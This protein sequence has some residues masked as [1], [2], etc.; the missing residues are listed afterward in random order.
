MHAVWDRERSGCLLFTSY[1]P[2]S[3]VPSAAKARREKSGD[4]QAFFE[5]TRAPALC[6][7]YTNV[8]L[9]MERPQRC[10]IHPV[11]GAEPPEDWIGFVPL[12]TRLWPS[13]GN[14]TEL[15]DR[16]ITAGR[17]RRPCS[18]NIRLRRDGSGQETAG[19]PREKEKENRRPKDRHASRKL[20]KF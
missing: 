8:L 5:A 12:E 19:T 11:C 10:Q 6:G 14:P 13:E 3:D 4:L 9:T 1:A 20:I 16:R 18:A 7:S 2:A 17:G 15:A